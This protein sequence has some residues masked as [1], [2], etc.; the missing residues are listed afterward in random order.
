MN[1]TDENERLEAI[2]ARFCTPK[3]R[4]ILGTVQP[5]FDTSRPN[6]HD[7]KAE[8]LSEKAVVESALQDAQSLL[9]FMMAS[10][11]SEDPNHDAAKNVR[12]LVDVSAKQSARS[13]K[14]ETIA[15][16]V[17]KNAVE[18]DFSLV[19]TFLLIDLTSELR[20]RKQE[21]ESQEV[22]FWTGKGR[23]PNHYA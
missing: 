10:F 5:P 9:D 22:I 14:V 17:R 18:S 20:K 13:D 12:R 15:D 7:T 6:S 19:M 1:D 3:P 2:V 21:L 23:S 11:R 16:L 8:F 4:T